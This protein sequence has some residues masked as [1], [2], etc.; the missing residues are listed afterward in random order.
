[1]VT[2]IYN[3][4]VIQKFEWNAGLIIIRVKPNRPL[5]QVEAGQYSVLGLMSQ[6]PRADKAQ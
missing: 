6:R 3:A 5:F 2:D 4:T 1:M